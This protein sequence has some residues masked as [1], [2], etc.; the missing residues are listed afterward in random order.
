MADNTNEKLDALQKKFDRLFELA[1]RTRG[2]QRE[3]F[4]YRASSDLEKAKQWEKSLDA[5]I[6]EEQKSR[7]SKQKELF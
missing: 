7:E 4:K 1:R 2:L 3:Y 5:F 6:N